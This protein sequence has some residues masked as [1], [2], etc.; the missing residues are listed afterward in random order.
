M[1]P[2]RA[3]DYTT[4]KVYV[5]NTFNHHKT[6]SLFENYLL[7]SDRRMLDVALM[8]LQYAHDYTAADS[9]YNQP[10]GPGNQLLTLLAG[11]DFTGDRKYLERCR[12]IVD[13]A[14]QMQSRYSGAFNEVRS[15]RFQYGI[16]LEGLLRYYEVTSDES[17]PPMVRQSVDFLIANN[18]TFTNCAYAAGFVYQQTKDP[19]YRDYGI[20]SV[21]RGGLA[22][23]PVKETALTFRSSPYFLYY[24]ATG[25]R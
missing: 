23:N 3:S 2:T 10:R 17:V 19:K 15:S 18:H 13:F 1:D 9:S 20:K 14:R 16:A 25:A 22:G 21:T 24:L 12:R 5:S 6:Q 7:T 11:Y 4:A 8:G